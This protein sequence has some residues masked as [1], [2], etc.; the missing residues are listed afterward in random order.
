MKTLVVAVNRILYR[1]LLKPV[2]FLF[3]PLVVH[4]RITRVGQRLGD[5]KPV[6]GVMALIFRVRDP[7]LHQTLFGTVFENPMGLAAGYDYEARLT[8]ILPSMG[9]GFG[10]VGT[11]TNASYGGNPPPLLGR[12][13]K[14][15][16]LMVNKGF[17]NDGVAVTL[18]RLRGLHFSYPVG[19]S[20][21]QTNDESISTLEEGIADILKVFWTAEASG[22]PFA[23][24]ELNVSC[25]NLVSTVDFYAP[26]RLG[27]LLAAVSKLDLTRPVFIKMPISKT[28]EEIRS[29][30]DEIVTH[31]FVKAVILGNLQRDRKHPTLVPEEVQKFSVGNWSGLPC[32][33]RSDELI[34]LVYKHFGKK[35]VIIGCGGVF[36]ADD[37]YRKLSLGASL[38]QMVTG[39]IFEGPQ[40]IA[41]INLGLLSRMR[42]EGKKSLEEVIGTVTL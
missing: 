21:G 34:V 39:L 37:A 6:R 15:K 40:V 22:V 26:E 11:L 24:Y 19:V 5:F 2:L 41:D 38:V 29:M 27:R 36:S 17:K 10:T 28:D 8:R 12:L 1:Y 31:P 30:M 35:I 32:Q 42:R 20:I 3:D 14:S 25:P 4:E 7:L 13:P 23:Y 18:R 33:S 16:S 9:F